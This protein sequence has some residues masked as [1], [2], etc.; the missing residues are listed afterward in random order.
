MSASLTAQTPPHTGPERDHHNR[1]IW[2]VGTLTYTRV[3]LISVFSWLLWGD[4]AWMI[5]ERALSPLV[6]LILKKFDTSDM[7]TGLLIVTLPGLLE[8]VL[9]P[10]VSVLSDRTRSRLGRRIPFLLATTPMAAAGIIGCAFSAHMG[11]WLHEILGDSSPGR[12]VSSL[13]CFTLWWLLFEI[14]TIVTNSLFYALINDVVPSPLLGRFFALFRAISLVAGIL[15]NLF[16]LEKSEKY[17][18][19]SF[20]VIGVVYGMGFL[21]MCLKVKEGTY[22]PPDAPAKRPGVVGAVK[23][24]LQECFRLP[25]YWWVFSAITLGSAVF[26][27]V[28]L[29]SI[30]HARS[31]GVD[32]GHYGQ[33]VAFTFVISIVL[34][35]PL[36]SL[37]DRFH[38]TRMALITLGLYAILSFW[39]GFAAT[40]HTGF[41]IAFIAHSVISGMFY[42]CTASMTQRLFPKEKFAQFQSACGI[43]SS[44]VNM[45]VAPGVGWMLDLTDNRYSNAYFF[46]LC[47]CVLALTAYV[48]TFR[49]FMQRGGPHDYVA[50]V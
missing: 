26:L 48:V 47:L 38:P 3:G 43:I 21:L 30:L 28:N 4:F 29:F 25:Y 44:L 13:L 49:Q 46:G 18:V 50:P 2:R 17:Y 19:F 39:G 31:L 40:T 8:L 45:A 35:Y 37:A 33:Y 24:Y 16:L 5:K 27:P 42:T 23:M 6:P 12:N 9:G 15:F 36:G 20:V 34:A 1:P 10:V 32:L 14:G 22:P 11:G 41:A 7:I